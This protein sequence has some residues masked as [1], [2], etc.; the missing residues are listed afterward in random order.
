LKPNSLLYQSESSLG[1]SNVLGRFILLRRGGDLN[2]RTVGAMKDG[3]PQK[4]SCYTDLVGEFLGPHDSLL[5]Q[6]C[7]HPSTIASLPPRNLHSQAVSHAREEVTEL[8]N[9]RMAS[10]PTILDAMISFGE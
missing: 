9:R 2:I 7:R 1:I 4:R 3:R 8:Q 5:A 10:R 6:E